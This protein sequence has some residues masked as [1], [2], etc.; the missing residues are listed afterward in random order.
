MIGAAAENF[1]AGV[2]QFRLCARK[3]C[4]LEAP[5]I[6][7][8]LL[9]ETEEINGGRIALILLARFQQNDAAR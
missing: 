3:G 7:I 6:V 4:G 5:V 1:G 9:I 8:G 2:I